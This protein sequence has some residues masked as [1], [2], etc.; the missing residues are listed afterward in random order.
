MRDRLEDFG[1]DTTTALVTFTDPKR[2]VDY[3][4]AH[5]FGFPILRDP[6]RAAYRAFGLGRGS[7]RRVWGLRA[8]RR[9]LEVIRS[10]GVGGV[11]LPAEDPLQLG[12]DF[13]IAPD[14]TV[15]FAFR[16]EG[17]DDRPSVDE[18]VAAV[19]SIRRP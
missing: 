8:A 14:G 7:V 1:A 4:E 16:S 9:Y 3:G 6:E 11:R 5:R 19:D 15:T 18:L 13:V 2:L 17:P 12:G 10:D